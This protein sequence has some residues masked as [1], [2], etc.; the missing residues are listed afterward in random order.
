MKKGIIHIGYPL[1]NQ[2]P[3]VIQ[4]LTHPCKKFLEP[5]LLHLN[6][7]DPLPMQTSYMTAPKEGRN[8]RDTGEQNRQSR[9]SLS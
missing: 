2:T 5:S 4:P 8:E 3:V 1:K 9:G 6:L 7:G